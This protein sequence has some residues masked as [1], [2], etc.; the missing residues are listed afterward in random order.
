MNADV[1]CSCW[2]PRSRLQPVDFAI[3][4]STMDLTTDEQLKD[5][6]TEAI[7]Q[8]GRAD[9]SYWKDKLYAR[10]VEKDEESS[11]PKVKEENSDKVKIKKEKN[12]SPCKRR[13]S[14]MGFVY[15]PD[16]KLPADLDDDMRME[17]GDGSLLDSDDGVEESRKESPKRMKDNNGIA[18]TPPQQVKVKFY[19]SPLVT[20]S[21]IG[22]A[23]GI[24]S[25]SLI[26]ELH[27]YP[28]VDY[29]N[30][31]LIER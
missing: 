5:A 2:T 9:L 21:S 8:Y 27:I 30:L 10:K 24:P 6:Y 14:D 1:K 20:P 17:D 31:K 15:P 29:A 19:P 7:E 26:P 18:V 25:M 4:T 3:A 12:N 13:V 28:R 16:I 22:T 23:R 11:S